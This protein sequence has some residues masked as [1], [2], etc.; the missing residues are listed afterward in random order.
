MN[1][2]AAELSNADKATSPLLQALEPTP[3][4]TPE[5]ETEPEQAPAPSAA[6]A[7]Q[8]TAIRRAK[9][10]AAKRL[11]RATAKAAAKWTAAA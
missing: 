6:P 10:A 3:E 11:Y 2:A 7:D 9:W 5:P 4:P 8:A 1:S